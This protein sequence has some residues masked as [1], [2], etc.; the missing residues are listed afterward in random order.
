MPVKEL[1]KSDPD[2]RE[3]EIKCREIDILT[4]IASSLSLHEWIAMGELEKII[5]ELKNDTKPIIEKIKKI[6]C[7]DMFPKLDTAYKNVIK[8]YPYLFD[9]TNYRFQEI[10]RRCSEWKKK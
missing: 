3:F 6:I 5:P 8:K 9:L 10:S 7:D 1:P 4:G 2:I